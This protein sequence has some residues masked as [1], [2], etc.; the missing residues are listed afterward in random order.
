MSE[1]LRTAYSMKERAELLL[2]N[3]G[4][5]RAEGAITE[6]EYDT[7]KAEYT[8]MVDEAI[9]WIESIKAELQK[10]LD[11]KAEELQE[12]KEDLGI[13]QAR[14]K[15]GEIARGI[16]RERGSPIEERVRGL[17]RKVSELQSLVDSGCSADVGGPG[18]ISLPTRRGENRWREGGRGVVVRL[19]RYGR[20]AGQLLA[21]LY[22]LLKRVGRAARRRPLLR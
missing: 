13:L 5:L 22:S 17:E 15:V 10:V 12:L 16:Y 4:R 7:L 18:D 20:G 11:G 14:L 1:D 6:T 8:H 19:S 9:P 21:R 3:L 2:S